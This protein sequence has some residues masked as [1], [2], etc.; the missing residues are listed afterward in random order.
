MK[1]YLSLLPALFL[2]A[3]TALAQVPSPPEVTSDTDSDLSWSHDGKND[4]GS[5][6]EDFAKFSIWQLAP[7]GTWSVVLDIDDFSVREV[8]LETGTGVHCF[9]IQAVDTSGNQSEHSNIACDDN[10]PPTAPTLSFTVDGETTT[11]IITTE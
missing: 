10:L 1:R 2:F 7:D 5:D 8:N 6:L 11:I 3:C 4:D 9:T